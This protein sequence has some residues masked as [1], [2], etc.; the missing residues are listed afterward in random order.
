MSRTVRRHYA[1][2]G[3]THDVDVTLERGRLHGH[4]DGRAVDADARL[5]RPFPGGADLVLTRESGR[6]RAVVLRDGDVVHVALGGRTYRFQV[7]SARADDDTRGETGVDPFVASPMTGVVRQV[8]AAVGARHAAGDTLVVVEA[9]KMEFA[10][11]APREVV[12][13]EVRVKSGDRVDIGQV[14]VTF[15]EPVPGTPA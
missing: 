7:V 2:A 1:A 15:A 5:V 11:S 12:I 8:V 6:R 10:V 14:L 13:G 4:V 9:M 3:A